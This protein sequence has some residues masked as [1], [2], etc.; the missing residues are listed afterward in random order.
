MTLQVFLT[1]KYCLGFCHDQ[2]NLKDAPTAIV[3]LQTSDNPAIVCR[4]FRLI[5]NPPH[6]AFNPIEPGPNSPGLRL[7]EEPGRK[8][9]DING[10]KVGGW[11][12]ESD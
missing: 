3:R 5:C 4:R 1:G 12:Y 8:L 2:S 7:S 11:D 10:N 6:I 9:M